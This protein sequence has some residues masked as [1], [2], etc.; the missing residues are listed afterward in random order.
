MRE[1]NCLPAVVGE[2]SVLSE[3]AADRFVFALGL[4]A[5][6]KVAQLNTVVATQKLMHMRF[7]FL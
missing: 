5:N 2:Y 4:D 6:G 7:D 1:I 3:G